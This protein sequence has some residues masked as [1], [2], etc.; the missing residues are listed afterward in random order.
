MRD[1]LTALAGAVIL[2][3]VAA[4]AV[5][6]FVGWEGY[7]GT[8]DRTITRSLGVE[9]RT[10][11]RIGLRLL[12]S[13]RLKLDR[14]RLG[15]GAGDRPNLDLPSLDLQWLKA[16]IALAPL[17]KG[18]IRFTETRI[19]RA[20]VRLPVTDGD[21]MLLPAGGLS[22]AARR[23]LAIEDLA[24][25]QFVLTTQV[26]AT[27]RVEQFY[28][29]ALRVSAPAI[30]G[31][32][33]A[34]GTSRGVP[35]R[36]STG[37]A[38][39]E[40]VSVKI[41]GGGDTQPRFEADARITLATLKAAPAAK[42]AGLRT[43]VP[44]AE[45]TARIVVGPPTQAAGAYLPFSLGG[46]FTARGLN[47]RFG[48]V[49]LEVDPGGQA[50]RLGGTGRLDLKQWRGGLALSARRLDLDAFLTS[51]S[52]QALIARGVPGLGGRDGL[53]LP[54]MLD[55][56]L[57]VE[58][59]ALGLDEWSGLALGATLDRTG[60]LVL[61]RL[62]VTAPGAAVVGASGEIDTETG[63]KTET[64]KAALRFT[65][66]L[67]LDAPASDGF[68]RYLRR[69]G[70]EGPMVAVMDGRPVQVATDL[71]VAAPS[72]S[73]RNLRLGLG[74]AR[75]TG[76]ARYTAGEGETRGRFDAQLVGQGLDIA[77]LPALGGT[78]SELKGH[79]LGLTFQARDVR[80]GPAHSGN[81]T[82]AASIQSDG[83]SLV[84]DSLDVTDLA[85][86]NARLSGR[87]A[88][89]GTGRIAG[90]VSAA[91]AA[92]LF[93]L[94]DR[95]WVAEA[96]HVPAF[97]RAGALDLAVNLERD[98]GAADT[99]RVGAKGNAAGGTLDLDL[100]SRAG[101]IE[102]LDLTVAAANAAPWFG[103]ADIPA[104]RRPG[105]LRLVGAPAPSQAGI[106][107]G[108]L[109]LRLSGTASDISV[110]T[111]Q[112][113]LLE[114]GENV[115]RA[116]ALQ[117]GIPDLTPL[118]TLAGSAA[119][120]P[121]PLPADLSLT[122]SRAGPDARI[123]IV[124]RIA[125]QPVSADLTR[126]PEGE[127]G[128]SATLARLS[129][130]QLASA[131]VLPL[132]PGGARFAA[133]PA[134]RPAIA[135]SLRVDALDLGRGLTATGA[136]LGASLDGETLTLRDLSGS[137]AGGRIAGSATLS[138]QGGA[139]AISGEGT[140][141]DA[142]IAG[143]A[144][145]GA[146][147]GRV[148]AQL[149]FG[150]SAESLIGLAN[151]LGGSGSLTLA[152]LRLPGADPAGLPRALT[153]ALAEDDPLREGRLA[154]LVAE[155]LGAG[156]LTVT[157]PVTSPASLVGGTLRAGPLTLDL[158][159]ARWTGT[160]GLDLRDARLDARGT[161]TA[162]A[163]PKGWSGAAPAIQLGF[164][165]PI[166]E[167]QRSLDAGPVTNGL[168]A[169]VLQR[170]LE[171]IEL[172]EAD[173]TERQRRRGRIEMDK[174]RAAALKAAADKAAADK[175]AAEKA[176]AEEAARQARLRAQQAAEEA[177]RQAQ[178]REQ[179]REQARDAEAAR[180]Q[181]P[182]AETPPGEAAPVPQP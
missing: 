10:E 36:V 116:G 102:T 17:L 1:I 110:A 45:G 68:G 156:P 115:P 108:A 82:I 155:E 97:L 181:R 62:D 172:F 27:G 132:D 175:L 67:S 145:E 15:A 111:V 20:E 60:G 73:L 87:I 100:L 122:L 109:A 7:R 9:A 164:G 114:P 135:L 92:P 58:S 93:A 143:L 66:R 180:R 154:A 8:I 165:G 18:E 125:G 41:A 75:I 31:P 98:A 126:A 120:L 16:E 50:L 12:P 70:V 56:D 90:R 79:D 153:R 23:D 146:V 140:I 112:P 150:A 42:A 5:P 63:P 106:A 121:G 117:L 44:E 103:R 166:R 138:R 95:V 29:E 33:R 49:A 61:R 152:G 101:R 99:L 158:G 148:T 59:L 77:T 32:W 182:D 144:G 19:G 178:A 80:Y 89:D 57:A 161:L 119:P 142:T 128:G 147:S 130:P 71:S 177:A 157:A 162:G 55:L 137:L 21:G 39:P 131:T 133:L 176:A 51:A 151:N 22:A 134:G 26:P 94:L 91:V 136:A 40:G 159:A 88:P 179:A 11:G 169:L 171:K 69:L 78:L 141:T 37:E 13:P 84:V 86:A 160:L 54:I 123:G 6:P 38:S 83:A 14:L 168:A 139:A 96:R 24:I 64:G 173:Q 104:L 30:L 76:N 4:L 124:G 2:L 53:G 129:L 72:L 127:I 118:L 25:K 34:E 170:E 3:L 48:D 167:P 74:E 149:R 81:G 52:G 65:G 174:A 163:S 35:F 28:A 107:A 47:A 43:V 46:K 113:V 85:G 105:R